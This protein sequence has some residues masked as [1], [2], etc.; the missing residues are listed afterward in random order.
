MLRSTGRRPGFPS[1]SRRLG[2]DLNRPH[3]AARCPPQVRYQ[4]H[5]QSDRYPVRKL[6]PQCVL[7]LQ[8]ELSIT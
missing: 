2:Q 3:I 8:Q 6:D 1:T 4:F 7:L 5:W